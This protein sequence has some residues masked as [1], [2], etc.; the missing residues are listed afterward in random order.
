MMNVV[1]Y[2]SKYCVLRRKRVGL[3][4]VKSPVEASNA[5]EIEHTDSQKNLQ[6]QSYNALLPFIHRLSAS[7]TGTT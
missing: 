2:S 1:L 3:R 6:K 4:R 7:S 5:F